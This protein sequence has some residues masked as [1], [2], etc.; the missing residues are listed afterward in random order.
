MP[1]P[2]F[3]THEQ[4]EFAERCKVEAEKFSETPPLLGNPVAIDRARTLI[5]RA[6]ELGL[7]EVAYSGLQ[8]IVSLHDTDMALPEHLRAFKSD[9]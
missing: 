2:I 7:P 9:S 5:D 8:I 4:L 3:L 6:V 1:E